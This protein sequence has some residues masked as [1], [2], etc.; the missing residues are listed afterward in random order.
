ML[1]SLERPDAVILDL[2]LPEISGE[3]IFHKLRALDDSIA[4][5]MLT[6]MADESV[7][8]GLL[9]AGAFDYLSNPPDFQRL[10]AA[11]ALAM[12]AGRGKSRPG[13]VVPFLSDRPTPPIAPVGAETAATDLPR[14][15][16]R[17]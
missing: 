14:R 1:A 9:R 7:A 17:L 5:V 8:R 3:Q 2:M 15:P 13:T 11:M 10:Y 16:H 12:A 6:G 4:I